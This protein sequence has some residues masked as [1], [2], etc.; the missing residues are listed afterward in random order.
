MATFEPVYNKYDDVIGYRARIRVAGYKP[1]SKICR[2]LTDAKKWAL[3]REAEIR[4]G[5]QQAEELSRQY[6]L[7]TVIERYR[8][9]ILPYKTTKEKSKKM[10]L[11]YLKHWQQTLGKY[12]LYNITPAVLK[13]EQEN[14]LT[15]VKASTVNR[16]FA[17]L[18][19]VFNIAQKEWNLLAENPLHKIKNLKEPRGRVRFLTETEL[20]RL[21][22]YA[23][24]ESPLLHLFVIMAVS[25]GARKSEILSLKWADIDFINNKAILHETKNNERRSIYFYGK[26]ELELKHRKAFCRKGFKYVFSSRYV[27]EPVN[28]Y[29]YWYKAVRKAGIKDFRIHDLRHCYATELARQGATLTELAELLGHKSY[30]MVKK[31]AHHVETH[32]KKIVKK[33]N[34]GLLTEKEG[35]Y[36]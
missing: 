16:Y 29:N 35:V 31:Y 27:D 26:A 15:K 22:H 8:N 30:N 7:E 14:L 5:K 13:R 19:H 6:T 24:I 32:A 28:I 3:Y 33:M 34:E 18:N 4:E 2:K 21:L 36:A 12:T 17:M 10:Q 1:E 11:I 25:T 20:A 9:K 23:R